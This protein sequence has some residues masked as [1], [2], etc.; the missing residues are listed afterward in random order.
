MPCKGIRKIFNALER[1][2]KSI[3]C[4]EKESESYSMPWKGIRNPS[5]ALERNQKAMQCLGKESE[6]YPMSS[7]G[8]WGS[9]RPIG[10]IERF[11]Y[12]APKKTGEQ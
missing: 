12:R 1:N 6:S 10:L 2:Q 5:N 7:K 3:Q 4:L 8:F 11:V 9:E